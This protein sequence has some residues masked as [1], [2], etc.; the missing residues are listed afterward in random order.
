MPDIPE[1]RAYP[2]TL[3]LRDVQA[4]GAGGRYNFLEGLAV[5]YDTW[6]DIGWFMEQHAAGSFKRSTTGRSGTRLPLLL[7]HDNRKWPVGHA[8]K[9]SHDGGLRGV[10]RLNDS[11]DAQTAAKMAEDGDLVGMSIGF[12][13]AAAPEWEF[14]REFDPDLGPDHKARVTRVESRLLEVSLTPTPAFADAGV[15]MVRTRAA[16]PPPPPRQVDRWRELLEE[17]KSR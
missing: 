10:W 16:C 12:A 15:T 14:P 5:P 4:V 1:A 9:W 6:A 13:D 7:F 8:E 17:L 11:S 2:V 3:E